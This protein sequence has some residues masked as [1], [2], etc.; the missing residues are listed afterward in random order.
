M[1]FPS[2]SAVKNPPHNT[3]GTRDTGSI[4]GL[5]GFPGAGNDNILEPEKFHA[6]RSLLGY[7]LWGR[8]E[9][10]TTKHE[11][12]KLKMADW[13]AVRWS[14]LRPTQTGSHH[15]G[16][17]AGGVFAGCVSTAVSPAPR[18]L[19][20]R[21]S[22]SANICWVEFDIIIRAD[23]RDLDPYCGWWTAR[24]SVADCCAVEKL[25]KSY[26]EPSRHSFPCAPTPPLLKLSSPRFNG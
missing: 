23:P 2:G 21:S 8:K 17:P 12:T 11:A 20:L 26:M 19:S 24:Q 5:V 14:L 15:R 3:G 13:Q 9:S 18:H 1:G 16:N 7:S 4:S 6:Q 22:H 25:K 10:D